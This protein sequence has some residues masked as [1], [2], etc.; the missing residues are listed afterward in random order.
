MINHSK[1]KKVLQDFVF[2]VRTV[3]DILRKLKPSLS[4]GPDLIPNL[5]LKRCAEELSE[6]L[7]TLFNYSFQESVLPCEWLSA[8]VCPLFKKKGD[9]SN[10]LNYKPI[11]LTSCVCKSMEKS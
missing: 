7:S 4:Y 2:N 9:P 10:C 11:S 6:P 5:I 8:R 3:F 1:S